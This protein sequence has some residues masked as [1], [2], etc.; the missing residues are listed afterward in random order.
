MSRELGWDSNQVYRRLRRRL[1]AAGV[2]FTFLRLFVLLAPETPS[3]ADLRQLLERLELQRA[4]R[5]VLEKIKKV[6]GLAK[7]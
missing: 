5:E 1:I 7:G 6:F 2:G 4:R 3:R